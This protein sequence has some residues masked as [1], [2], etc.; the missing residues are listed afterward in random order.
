[1]TQ[2]ERGPLVLVVDDDA[3]NA[4]L[5]SRIL[6]AEGMRSRIAPDGETALALVAAQ[7]PDMVLLD[8]MMPGLDG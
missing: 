1:M 7:L 6:E 5:L 3:R 2:T 8:V 4:K